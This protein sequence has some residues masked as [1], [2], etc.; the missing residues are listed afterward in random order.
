MR[1]KQF[2]DNHHVE[3]LR[4]FS[5]SRKQARRTIASRCNWLISKI[6]QR[7]AIQEPQSMLVEELA[8]LI[9]LVEMLDVPKEPATEPPSELTEPERSTK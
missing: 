1:G 9:W 3:A 5:I 8:A 6:A 7:T 2:P 4:G